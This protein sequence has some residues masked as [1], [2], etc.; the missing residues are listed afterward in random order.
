[1]TPDTVEVEVEGEGV[2][3]CPCGCGEARRASGGTVLRDGAESGFMALY[4]AHADP[5]RIHWLLGT[6]SW[7]PDRDARNFWVAAETWCSKRGF[8]TRITNFA[9]SPL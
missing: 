1:M 4:G 3:P 5:P 9:E 2:R 8:E 6:Q 7:H